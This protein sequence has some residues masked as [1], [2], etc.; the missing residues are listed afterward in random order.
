MDRLTVNRTTSASTPLFNSDKKFYEEEGNAIRISTTVSPTK[1][2]NLYNGKPVSSS[3]SLNNNSPND[4]FTTA[5][6]FSFE[7]TLDS[8]NFPENY[9]S[10]KPNFD[11]FNDETPIVNS[12]NRRFAN[13]SNDYETP[14]APL[15]IDDTELSN[16]DKFDTS[17]P[18]GLGITSSHI[19]IEEQSTPLKAIRASICV[20]R[21]QPINPP[22]RNEKRLQQRRKDSIFSFEEMAQNIPEIPDYAYLFIIANHSFD[23]RTLENDEDTNICLSF[24]ASDVAFVHN[25]DESGWGE[26]TLLQTQLRGWVPFNYFS[27]I[28]KIT[29]VT[30]PGDELTLEQWKEYIDSRLPLEKLL[31]ASAKF[32]A[33]P[34]DKPISNSLQKTFNLNYINDIRDGVKSLLQLTDAVS[35]SNEIV[36]AKEDVRKGRKKLLADWYNLMIKADYYKHTTSSENISKLV[37]LVYQ[38][39]KRA[40]S[41]YKIWSLEK[42]NFENEKNEA[43]RIQSESFLST[44]TQNKKDTKMIYR[45]QSVKDNK[46]TYL[47]T[48]PTASKRLNE[49]NDLLF[50]YIGL[51][52]GRINLVEHNPNGCEALEFIIHQ[53]IKLLRELLYVSKACSYVIEEKYKHAYK[54]TLDACL[55]PLLGL[56]SE[57]V[58]CIKILVTKSLSH[59]IRRKSLKNLESDASIAVL[60]SNYDECER[61]VYI[62]S[63]MTGLIANTVAGCNNYLRI[64]GDFKL[65]KNREYPDLQMSK[66]TPEEFLKKC[67]GG[68]NEK[69][70]NELKRKSI[71]GLGDDYSE[72]DYKKIIR[73]SAIPSG[74]MSAKDYDSFSRDST[75]AKY[76][77]LESELNDNPLT[78][79]NYKDEI[80]RE[81]ILD[82]ERNLNGASFRAIIFKL[83]DEMEKPDELFVATFLLTFRMYGNSVDLVNG[84]INRF[85]LIDKSSKFEYTEK[86]GTY[87][88]RASRLKNRRRLVCNVFASW[89]ESYWDH[90]KDYDILPTMVNFFNEGMST[91]LPI[92]AKKLIEL[93]SKLFLRKPALKDGHLL[94]AFMVDQL[95]KKSITH[96]RAL[97]MISDT[98]SVASSIRS[99]EFSLDERII[100]KYELTKI[101]K[102]NRNSVSLPLP[103]LNLGN[104]SFL[105]TDD[106]TN[107]ERLVNNYRIATN[108]KV[109]KYSDSCF[110]ENI[111]KNWKRLQVGIESSLA[112][113]ID[114]VFVQSDLNLVDMN[115][116]E[117]AKQLTLIESKLFMSIQPTELINYKR[118]SRCPNV[119]T[120]LMF[121]NKFCNYV[122]DSLVNPNILMIDRVDRLRNWLRIALSNLY[123][124]NFNSV[125]SIMT[126]L[127][128][129]SITRLKPIWQQLSKQDMTLYEYLA[130]IV[131]P[132]KN[133][134]VYRN[135]LKK[136]MGDFSFVKVSLPVV[137]YFNLFLQD[138]T[139]IDEGNPNFRNP[140]AFRPNKIVNMDKFF[141]ITR[142][143]STI[144]YLQVNY[145]VGNNKS[146]NL[147]ESELKDMIEPNETNESFFELTN[148]MNVDTY[149]ITALPLLQE[150]IL[151][152]FWRVD[153][154][155]QKD[156]DR[157]YQLSLKILPRQ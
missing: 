74:L 42:M 3:K 78:S 69:H 120:V 49:V 119:N 144:Q 99:S 137:P 56:V 109:E 47:T 66:L 155:H 127:Q 153:S 87:S 65:N 73:F 103:F 14:K 154:L 108:S 53:M 7:E 85:D 129:H 147:K 135:K 24:N 68:I 26:V 38:I 116:M 6:S 50:S 10:L 55:D 23:A 2:L 132:N 101:D 27:D 126:A 71:M 90:E 113:N 93:A 136:I 25:V 125:A 130:R 131:H 13:T 16:S 152:E 70:N 156:N 140:D 151:Y 37:S 148:Q 36:Q 20:Q 43:S 62:I 134:K 138:L 31:T 30:K 149:C 111:I 40:F 123:F 15:Y 59:E 133:F 4:S 5:N 19:N 1:S 82:N 72:A 61:L 96:S 121:T 34:Q 67:S 91:I 60:P 51:I 117:V 32:I 54:N 124:R 48:V 105:T 88:S 83:T 80:L 128:N 45:T 106:I 107:M 141:R 58:S 143:I 145:D 98:S 94:H 114:N 41:F 118:K 115:P 64:T 29:D 92:E 104:S 75:F 84:L 11:I 146:D 112:V 89:M 17:I 21:T 46:I 28:I 95:A 86:N 102:K 57:L 9:N 100:E 52:L 97:S 18:A 142:I 63:K 8:N 44:S 22:Q 77:P 39:L 81:I 79:V 33:H 139:F 76:R 122:I 35:R 157:S 12:G 150:F 110:L